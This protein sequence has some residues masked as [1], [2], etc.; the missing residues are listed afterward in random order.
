MGQ[1]KSLKR[2]LKYLELNENESTTNQK[3][4]VAALLREKFLALMEKKNGLNSVI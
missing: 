3:L 1:R 4:C 2:T